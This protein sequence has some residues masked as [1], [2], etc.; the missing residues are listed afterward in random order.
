MDSSQTSIGNVRIKV[1]RAQKRVRF[2][3]VGDMIATRTACAIAIFR[4]T[5]LAACVLKPKQLVFI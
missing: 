2:E 4:P 1:V 3:C 5:R